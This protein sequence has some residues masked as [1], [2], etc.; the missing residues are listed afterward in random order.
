MAHNVIRAKRA[1]SGRKDVR[2]ACIGDC[3][4]HERAD[5]I[6]GEHPQG[7]VEE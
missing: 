6:R 5:E 4:E 3:S 2:R 7:N 1:A